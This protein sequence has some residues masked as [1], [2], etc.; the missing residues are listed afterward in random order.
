[1]LYHSVYIIYIY[2]VTLLYNIF[3]DSINLNTTKKKDKKL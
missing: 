3:M 1:M 2:S